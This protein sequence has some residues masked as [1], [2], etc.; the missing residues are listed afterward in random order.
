MRAALA[1]AA[2]LLAFP[3]TAQQ[4]YDGEW[5]GAVTQ[6]DSTDGYT[7]VLSISGLEGESLYPELGC[8]GVLTEIAR[9]D[10]VFTYAETIVENRAGPGNAGGCIDGTF[11]VSGTSTRL[12]W[13]WIGTYQG[14][15]YL[16]YAILDRKPS[17]IRPA[18]R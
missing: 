7:L 8:R 2:C 13:S 14:E 9:S 11:T 16:A 3:V 17:V 5:V 12:G 1:I 4:F 6:V 15:I 18:P 10:G